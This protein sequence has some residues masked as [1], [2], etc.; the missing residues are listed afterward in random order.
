MARSKKTP[1]SPWQTCKTDGIEQRYIR[2]GNS[3]MLHKAMKS[4]SP[5]AFK[6]YTYMLQESGGE[7]EFEYP[8]VKFES[9]VSKQGFQSAKKELIEKG[10]IA[11]KENN[12][13]RR[14]A[15]KYIFTEDW[16]RYEPP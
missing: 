16:K 4:L 15:N 7:K 9:I 3:Q 13:H 14:K 6:V 5:I 12:A 2:L 10:F 1:F 11:E 8:R